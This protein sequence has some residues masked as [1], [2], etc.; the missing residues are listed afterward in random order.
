MQ[1]GN[2]VYEGPKSLP[3]SVPL[4]PLPSGILLPRGHLPLNVFESHIIDMVDFAMIKERIIG[5][6][7]PKFNIQKSKS[8]KNTPPPLCSVGCVGRITSLQESGDGRYLVILTG[9]CRFNLT[10]EET[11]SN[12]IRVAKVSYKNY[13]KDFKT[14]QNV[15][16]VDRDYFLEVLKKYLKANDLETDWENVEKTSTETLVNALS[17]VSPFGPAEKQA[18]LEAESIP[19]RAKTL[20]AIAE[21]ELAKQNIQSSNLLQ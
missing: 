18:L 4:F 3:T 21:M 15:E 7:Q 19:E 17:M 5:I 1:I 10:N 2:A 11:Q 6:I 12:N 14:G 13:S 8:K 9:I 20:I 16:E